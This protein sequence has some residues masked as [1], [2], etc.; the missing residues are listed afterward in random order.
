[1]R[2]PRLLQAHTGVHVTPLA[3]PEAWPTDLDIAVA[4]RAVRRFVLLDPVGVRQPVSFMQLVLLYDQQHDAAVV[5]KA[6]YARV[7]GA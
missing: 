4:D 5:F 6:A 2:R 1:M 7:I 3:E